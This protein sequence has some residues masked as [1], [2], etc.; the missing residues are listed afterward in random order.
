MIVTLP[1]GAVELIE[2]HIIEIPQTGT[3]HFVGFSI[4]T[5]LDELVHL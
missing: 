5:N 2:W 4:T 1:A 3:R